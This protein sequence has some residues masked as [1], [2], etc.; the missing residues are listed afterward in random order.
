MKKCPLCNQTYTD[1]SLNFCLNDGGTL[2]KMS[3]E[4]PPTIF[5]NQA[6]TTNQSNWANNDPFSTPNFGQVSPWQNNPSPVQNPSYMTSTPYQ[7]QNQ[8]LATVSLVLG[9]LGILLFCCYGGFYFGIAAMITGYLGFNSANK[10][11][12]QYGGKGLAIAGMIMGAISFAG[13]L[14]MLFFA[15]IG[16]IR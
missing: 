5:M 14:L 6:R 12:Q 7:G 3:D 13:V 10:D 16:N 9:I 1:E 11:P 8:T 4:A 15:I 2:V